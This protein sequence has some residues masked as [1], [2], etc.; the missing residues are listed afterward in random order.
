MQY[1]TASSKHTQVI[2]FF[3]K[4]LDET[5]ESNLK[6]KDSLETR[7]C[8]LAKHRFIKNT[9]N[10]S[11][12]KHTQLFK[13]RQLTRKLVILNG[14]FSVAHLNSTRLAHVNI[15]DQLRSEVIIIIIPCICVPLPI[16][17]S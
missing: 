5:P 6:T 17:D 3:F 11:S 12:R 4:Y 10:I 9:Y 14:I 15:T 2:K 1:L 8:S 7:P 13:V 16:S